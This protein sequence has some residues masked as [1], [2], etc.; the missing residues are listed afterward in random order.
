MQFEVEEGYRRGT[1]VYTAEDGHTY[2]A[3]FRLQN[4]DRIYLK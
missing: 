1:R 2:L 3:K 4:T